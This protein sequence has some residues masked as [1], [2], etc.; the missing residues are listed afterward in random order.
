MKKLQILTLSMILSSNFI[1]PSDQNQ[2]LQPT[3]N[4][5]N[6]MSNSQQGANL[7]AKKAAWKAKRSKQLT[8]T[9][10]GPISNASIAESLQSAANAVS[11][12]SPTSTPADGKAI[13]QQIKNAALALKILYPTVFVG[14]QD[15][16]GKKGKNQKDND[17]DQGK[18]RKRFRENMM[19]KMSNQDTGASAN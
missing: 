1:F 16:D 17:Q 15:Q 10:G 14:N 2:S 5:I 8:K 12:L 6:P 18:R 11:N 7:Q 9:M 3:S 13:M 19:Q 4:A